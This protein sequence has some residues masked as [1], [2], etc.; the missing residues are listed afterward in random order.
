[1]RQPQ[2][3]GISL[4]VF[5]RIFI[6]S[7]FRFFQ[8]LSYA[9]FCVSLI[10][11]VACSGGVAMAGQLLELAPSRLAQAVHAAMVVEQFAATRVA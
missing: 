8:S 11:I 10:Q 1:M 6:D 5:S 4:V 9:A 2:R 3:N 7:A